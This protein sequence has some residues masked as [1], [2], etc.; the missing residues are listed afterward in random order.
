MFKDLIRKYGLGIV[1][2]FATLDG[3][4]RSVINDRNN[5]VLDKIKEER[6]SLSEEQRKLV[7]ESVALELKKSKNMETMDK[8][9][10]SADEHKKAADKY[11][12]DPSVE[13][14][15][16]LDITKK[17]M[18]VAQE[19]I[20]NLDFSDF[21]ISCYNK[22]SEFLDSLT[23]DKIVCLFNIII[24]CVTLTSLISILSIL[25]SEN[26]INKIV[27]LE[28]YPRLL[29]LLKLRS[30]INKKVS[31]FFFFMHLF[32]IIF[33]ILGNILMFFS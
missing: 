22:Y 5:N 19:E 26:I 3:Y 14:K 23:P 6:N 7:D 1:L 17:K 2:S 16:D 9:K 21:F 30:N 20:K 33:G 15:N 8:F 28:K 27:F 31:K 29:K 11:N 12:K 18:D 4:R 25:L 13:N 32:W 10:E 24:G